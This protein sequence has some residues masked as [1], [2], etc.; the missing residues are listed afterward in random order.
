ME[1][2]CAVCAGAMELDGGGAGGGFCGAWRG[3][4]CWRGRICAFFPTTASVFWRFLLSLV[5]TLRLGA[6]HV[7]CTRRR[8]DFRSREVFAV[9]DSSDGA[10]SACSPYRPMWRCGILFRCHRALCQL[11]AEIHGD[12][13][14]QRYCAGV[15]SAIVTSLYHRKRFLPRLFLS[16]APFVYALPVYLTLAKPCR[17]PSPQKNKGTVPV[18][19]S[20]ICGRKIATFLHSD[21]VQKLSKLFGLRRI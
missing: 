15:C 4:C 19:S 2:R 1:L 11:C 5:R 13:F 3:I 18:N 14:S 12:W 10:I 6:A 16:S 7:F 8:A 9:L 21:A 17:K 20:L